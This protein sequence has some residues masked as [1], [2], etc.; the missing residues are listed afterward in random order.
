MNEEQLNETEEKVETFVEDEKSELEEIEEPYFDEE[1]Y[2]LELAKKEKKVNKRL[3]LILGVFVICSLVYL[4]CISTRNYQILH[5][6]SDSS[7]ASSE[8]TA[9]IGAIAYLKYVMYFS[10]AIS[11]AGLIIMTLLVAG[12]KIKISYDIKARIY[13]IL[14]WA[15]LLP[16]CLVITTMCFSLFFTIA[17]VDGTSMAP[18]FAPGDRLF[19]NY[20]KVIENEDVVI[21]YVDEEKYLTIDHTRLFVK[22]VVALPGDVISTDGKNFY[23]NG[24][25]VEPSY[26]MLNDY[27]AGNKSS[28]IFTEVNNNFCFITDVVDGVKEKELCPHNAK[29]EYTIPEGYYLVLGDNRD[30][31]TDSRKIGLIEKEDILGVV[32]RKISGLI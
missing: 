1:A 22:R 9:S 31:S 28:F 18:N 8:A 25:K 27:F 2:A 4:A 13:S 17:E 21:I 12:V 16:I 20:N 10:Y 19:V 26:E 3:L 11:F 5:S 23:L 32:T 15:I 14:D 29:Y 30:N 6:G 24:K 7:F